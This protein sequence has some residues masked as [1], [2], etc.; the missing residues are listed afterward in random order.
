MVSVRK[1][2]GSTE[3]NVLVTAIYQNQVKISKLNRESFIA[4]KEK[5][6]R[7]DDEEVAQRLRISTSDSAASDSDAGNIST[8][9]ALDQMTAAASIAS[10]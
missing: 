7:D 9:I 1:G 8:L 3:D 10:R 5:Q 6:K 4:T 2:D